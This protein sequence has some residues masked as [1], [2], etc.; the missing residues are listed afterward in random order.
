MLAGL[1]HARVRDFGEALGRTMPGA[2][3][4]VGVGC[5]LSQAGAAALLAAASLGIARS[6]RPPARHP[7]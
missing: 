6:A 1:G 5:G 2:I 3:R 4:I 7:S